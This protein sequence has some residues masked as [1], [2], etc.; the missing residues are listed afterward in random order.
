MK[1]ALVALV[2]V[3]LHGCAVPRVSMESIKPQAEFAS[4][5]PVDGRL[6]VYIPAPESNKKILLHMRRRDYLH[7]PGQDLKAATMDVARKYFKDTSAFALEKQTHYVLK[8]GSD[9]HLDTYLGV[10]KVFVHAELYDSKGELVKKADVQESTMS[11][12]LVDQNAFYDSYARAVKSFFDSVIAESLS[13]IEAYTRSTP[14]MTVAFDQMAQDGKLAPVATGTA[15]IVNGNGEAV[16][17]YHVVSD[18]LAVTLN[19]RGTPVRARVIAS[20]AD[21][22]L[23]VVSTGARAASHA[24]F[25]DGDA[26]ARLGEDIITIG[27]PLSTVLSSKPNL[28]T[29]NVSALAGL[30]DDEQVMQLTAP[31]QPGSSGSPV[32]SRQGLLYGVVLGKLDAVKVARVTGDIPQNVNFALKSGPTVDFLKRSHVSFESRAATGA[33]SKDTP[34]IADEASSYTVQLACFG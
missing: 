5:V 13:G 6:L 2:V 16:T 11:A 7:R 21:R 29:G 30:H 25:I 31:V 18:C 27:Y 15:F 1:K 14:P 20:D 10:Y 24:V 28:T 12:L 9:A 17:A 26:H 19:Q 8:I 22:D 34:D 33:A 32:L 4:R 23:A 3:S